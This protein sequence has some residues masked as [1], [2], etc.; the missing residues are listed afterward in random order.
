M[1]LH[2][3]TPALLVFAFTLSWT[4]VE[5][6]APSAGLPGEEVVLLRYASH[7]LL[8][9]AAY[10]RSAGRQL[11]H[12]D[13]LPLQIVR[14]L[15]MLVMPLSYLAAVRYVPMNDALAGFW[16]APLLMLAIDR[17]PSATPRQWAGAL[18]GFAG[19][20]LILRPAAFHPA[21]LLCS[22]VMAGAFALYERLTRALA[23]DTPLANL[24]H[25]ALWV[26]VALLFRVVPRWQPPTA[27]GLVAV[28]LVGAIGFFGL[29]AFHRAIRFGPA[30][31]LAPVLYV[32]PAISACV[33][34]LAGGA[35]P[36]RG[37]LVGIFAITLSLAISSEPIRRGPSEALT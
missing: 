6:I 18:L 2:H 35:A 4:A 16:I 22:L 12:T 25:T 3:L 11:Y 21:A 10:G 14:S 17:A 8:M 1:P 7:L 26:F 33:A 30:G 19:T 37:A 28:G 32:Q 24:F 13:R 34:A 5:M 29:A 31:L 27:W 23:T 36:A 15:L 20:L 9:L